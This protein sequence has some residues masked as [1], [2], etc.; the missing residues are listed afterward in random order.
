M[1]VTT[2][3]LHDDTLSCLFERALRMYAWGAFTSFVTIVTASNST[4]KGEIGASGGGHRMG[5]VVL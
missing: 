5:T 2:I 3:K 4:G 1:T